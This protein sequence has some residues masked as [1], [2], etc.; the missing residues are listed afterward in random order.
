MLYVE[1]DEVYEDLYN[2][3]IVM[4]FVVLFV[5]FCDFDFLLGVIM[6]ICWVWV[7]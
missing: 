6:V 3:I 2:V 7:L 1:L 5:V 4:D